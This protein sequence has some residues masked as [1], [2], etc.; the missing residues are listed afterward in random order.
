[1]KEPPAYLSCAVLVV[2]VTTVSSKATF[3][4]VGR[5]LEPRRSSLTPE[6]VEAL[7]CLKD[8]ES[9]DEWTQHQLE[10]P[11]VAEAI[12]DLENLDVN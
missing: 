9:A 7:T 2:P 11:E 4:M 6:M 12:A 5:I 3:S 1:M 10:D 8:W